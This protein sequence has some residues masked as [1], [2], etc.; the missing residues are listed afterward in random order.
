MS[1]KAKET[2]ETHFFGVGLWEPKNQW[3]I[4]A[5][6]RSMG[7][8]GGSFLAV[9][10]NRYKQ[11]IGDFRNM[12]TEFARKRIPCFLGV[13]SILDFIPYDSEI[14][15]LERT[16]NSI[17]L[18]E[19][20]HPRRATYVFGPEDGAV[21]TDEFGDHKFTSVHIPSNGSLNLSAACYI[22]LY[23]R[24]MKSDSFVVDNCKC[25]NCGSV[26]LKDGCELNEQGEMNYHCNA[27][28][29]DWFEDRI[30]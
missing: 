25:P 6:M 22:T 19:F 18:H 30:N 17:S 16:S 14:V 1:K 23:D 11:Q 26:Y 20:E 10:G 3:N 28:G 24:I 27:C 21:P 12:D 2:N 8:F 7:C 5:V 15:V 29:H 13:N 9:S 4:G